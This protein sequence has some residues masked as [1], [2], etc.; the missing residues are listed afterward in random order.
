M[1]R[2]THILAEQHNRG[3]FLGSFGHAQ[4]PLTSDPKTIVQLDICPLVQ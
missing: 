1:E 4:I 2:L 3:I